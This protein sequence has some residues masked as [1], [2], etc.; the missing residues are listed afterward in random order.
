MKFVV[1]LLLFFFAGCGK[2]RVTEEASVTP[3]AQCDIWTYR[4]YDYGDGV[5]RKS[6]LWSCL[7][8]DGQ[9]CNLIYGIEAPSTYVATDCY[10]MPK[11][12]L[13]FLPYKAQH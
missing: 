7:D 11:T 2:M 10:G 4:H 5:D 8:T 3:S 9:E 12:G 13:S 1:I 6:L